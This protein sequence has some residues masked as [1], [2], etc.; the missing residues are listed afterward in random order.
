[1]NALV[2]SDNV[3]V[4]ARA[5]PI[6]EKRKLSRWTF[7][8]SDD[9]N[10]KK[11]FEHIIN[12]YDR[13]FSLHC[14]TIFPEVLTDN[15]RCFN[16]HPGL[17][18]YNKGIFPHVWSIINKLP[19]GAT[20]HYMT[21]CVD[22]GPYI[23]QRQVSIYDYDTSTTLY[24]RV[25]NAELNLLDEWLDRILDVQYIRYAYPENGNYNSLAD[26]KRLCEID[27]NR[28]GTFREFYDLLRALSHVGYMNASMDGIKFKLIIYENQNPNH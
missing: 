3:E 11:D 12:T 17:C 21:K 18:P 5:K 24:E 7:T 27:A 9:I 28:I 8:N 2:L 19:A 14:K 10:P 26:F 16:I 6:F 1:M 4:L 22:M 25:V 20:I 23:A 13:V 15:V